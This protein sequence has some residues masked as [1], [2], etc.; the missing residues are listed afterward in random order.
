MKWNV[1]PRPTSLSSQISPPIIWTSRAEIARPSPVPPY[2]RVVDVSA[3][4]KALK[5][6][7]CLSGGM[8][9][10]VSLTAKC[11]QTSCSVRDSHLDPE[12][13][14]PRFGE[15]DGVAD[16]V[17]DDLAQAV[18][19]AHQGIGHVGATW[20]ASSS[21]FLWARRASVATVSSRVSRRSK[22][23]SPGRAC[24]PRS[25]RSRGCR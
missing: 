7:C 19:V 2:L 9:M 24:R 22:S 1:L 4:E 21:P 5:S 16:Q 17:D 25:W 6:F 20:P 15:L 11:R 8:P 3:W 13:H 23:T 12:H 14:L 18:G 10:P